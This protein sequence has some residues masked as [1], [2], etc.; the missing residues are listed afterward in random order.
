VS[1]AKDLQQLRTRLPDI[2]QLHGDL[3]TT[4]P[5]LDYQ[6]QTGRQLLREV[7]KAQRDRL[8]MLLHRQSADG[9][10]LLPRH[11][12]EAISTLSSMHMVVALMTSIGG[13]EE[14]RHL[15]VAKALWDTGEAC[16][17]E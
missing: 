8:V 16:L 12:V 10:G 5:L 11:A 1:G 6:S 15:E 9:R 4:A 17:S 3:A 13:D 14:R 2:C 7:V